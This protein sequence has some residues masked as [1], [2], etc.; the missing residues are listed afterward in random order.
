[1]KALKHL[2]GSRPARIAIILV[3]LILGGLGR[4]RKPSTAITPKQVTVYRDP[5]DLQFAK[6]THLDALD[7]PAS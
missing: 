1:M 3:W 7:G 5:S 6:G 4:C 2:F